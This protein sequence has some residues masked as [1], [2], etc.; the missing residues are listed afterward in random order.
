VPTDPHDPY[1]SLYRA[2]FFAVLAM[3]VLVPVQIG[4]FVVNPMPASTEGWFRL[5]HDR[6]WIALFHADF[7]LLI[8]NVLISILYLAFYHLLKEI[9]RGLVQVGVLLGFLGIAA[10]LSSNKTFELLSLA[11]QYQAVSAD[12]DRLIL[13]AAGK[14]L[15]AGWQ[16]TAFD[17]YYVLNGITLLVLA[18]VMFR[19]PVFGRVTAAFGLAS[20]VLMCVPSTAGTVG[21]VFSLLSLIPWY[22]FSL[23]VARKLGALGNKRPAWPPL[24]E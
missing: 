8:N 12:S 15:L 11:G 5:F 2:A 3:L 23:L 19:S 20:G 9:N 10:Y 17:V 16:G 7:F 24:Q 18:S 6:P 4:V 13:L 22:G 21:L 14:A 1:R